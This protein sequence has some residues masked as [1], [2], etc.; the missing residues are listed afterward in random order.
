ML[1]WLLTGGAIPALLIGCG[2]FFTFYLRGGPLLHPVLMLR[3]V[4]QSAPNASGRQVSP[5]RALTLSLAGTLGVGNIVGVASAI[6]LGGAGAILW[7]WISA[8]FAMILKYAEILLGVSHRRKGR[9]GSFF[10][11]AV[12]Y[13][14]DLIESLGLKKASAFFSISFACLLLLNSLSM[15]CIIQANAVSAALEGV[16]EIPALHTGLLL[17]ILTLPVLL[18]EGR[19]LFRV[20]ELLVPIMTLGYVLLSAAALW[21]RRDGLPDAFG[22][23]LRDAFSPESGIGGV[24]GFLTSRAIQTGTMRGLLSNEAGCGTAPTAHASADAAGPS[25]QGVWGILEVFVDTILLCTATAL[26]IL[27]AYGDAI[28]RGVEGVMMTVQAYASILGGWS[29]HFFGGAVFCFGWATILCW[30]KYGLE[31]LTALTVKKK[32]RSCYL[33][34]FG[35]CAVAGATAAHEAIWGLADFAIAALTSINLCA[36]IGLRREIRAETDRFLKRVK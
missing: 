6:S 2:G 34:V 7:M 26:V 19:Y 16:W 13:I 24:V 30:G 28:P 5:F 18:R 33:L 8:L 10:G 1:K 14:R 25:E 31:S 35:V 17:L 32:W 20:T 23:I 12:Y 3:A 27:L 15:G 29:R 9:D 4:T 21:I 36:L 22:M 11:G